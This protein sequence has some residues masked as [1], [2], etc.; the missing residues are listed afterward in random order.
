MIALIWIPFKFNETTDKLT[1]IGE[2]LSENKRKIENLSEASSNYE[3]KI[4]FVN[5]KNEYQKKFHIY[6]PE[7]IT[8]IENQLSSMTLAASPNVPSHENCYF[9]YHLNTRLSTKGTVKFD[10]DD[11]RTR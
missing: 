1:I 6:L 4:Q 9:N 2:T 8:K 11:G 3:N 5:G 7:K 10:I